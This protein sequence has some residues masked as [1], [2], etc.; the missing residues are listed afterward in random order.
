M[1]NST[2]NAITRLRAAIDGWFRCKSC[3]QEFQLKLSEASAHVL[4]SE[5]LQGY[6]EVSFCCPQC[7]ENGKG[8]ITKDTQS[9]QFRRFWCPTCRIF[10]ARAAWKKDGQQAGHRQV[11]GSEDAKNLYVCAQRDPTPAL[12]DTG[13]T[14]LEDLFPG[15]SAELVPEDERHYLRETNEVLP[16]PKLGER[17]SSIIGSERSLSDFSLHD[18][19]A[20]ET[21]D[22]I[23]MGGDT[24]YVGTG[25]D[26]D[27]VVLSPTVQFDYKD[28]QV[29]LGLNVTK[30][31]MHLLTSDTHA[32]ARIQL[33]KHPD[34]QVSVAMSFVR[35][36]EED[37]ERTAWE[38]RFEPFDAA[39]ELFDGLDVHGSTHISA[40]VT[41][42]IQD[43]TELHGTELHGAEGCLR[44]TTRKPADMQG[45]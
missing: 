29:K 16:E 19:P 43:G 9:Y 28:P 11:S 27:A 32:T 22:D 1:M 41:L 15:L 24:Y 13:G 33:C 34:R 44:F 39:R 30:Q 42:C 6:K 45:N 26:V 10:M 4:T 23:Y 38:I 12:V 25:G 20:R 3:D 7:K 40:N 36:I 21:D 31:Y 8:K 17:G 5:D 35:P 18:N 2:E 37:R 14:L